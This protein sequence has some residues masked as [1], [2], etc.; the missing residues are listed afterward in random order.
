M[1]YYLGFLKIIPKYQ[2]D[3]NNTISSTIYEQS[4][5][6]DD[7]EEDNDDEEDLESVNVCAIIQD[8]CTYLVSKELW[9]CI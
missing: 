7:P 9:S 4:F 8:G 5:S 6:R 2:R 1:L 3:I